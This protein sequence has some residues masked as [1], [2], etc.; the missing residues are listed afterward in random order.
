MPLPDLIGILDFMMER[1]NIYLKRLHGEPPPWT[2]DPI[3]LKYKFTNVF[4]ELDRTTVWMRENLVGPCSDNQPGDLLLFNACVFRRFGTIEFS[5]KL[6]FLKKWEPEKVM[7][8]ANELLV[9]GERVFTGAY[10]IPNMGLSLPKTEVVVYHTLDPIW[11]VRKELAAVAMK[12]RSL[13]ETHKAFLPYPSWGGSGF[14]AYEVVSDL[15]W[16][17]LL[18]TASDI[19]TWANPGVGAR[20]GLNRLY[21]RPYEQGCSAKQCLEEMRIIFSVLSEVWDSLGGGEWGSLSMRE[22]EHSLCEWDKYERV[23][24]GQGRPRSTFTPYQE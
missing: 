11:K 8:L 7:K 12:T 23:R 13:E 5:Q 9:K 15:R 22:I 6:G 16:S 1:H 18:R 17:S 24:L 19:M 14:M 21:G 20:R 3:L 2:E 10:N 4:R